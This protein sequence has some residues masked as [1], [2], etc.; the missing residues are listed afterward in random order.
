[1]THYELRGRPGSRA[2][3]ED[4]SLRRRRDLYHIAGAYGL[5]GGLRCADIQRRGD[6]VQYLPR[7]LADTGVKI[8]HSDV[9]PKSAAPDAWA[10]QRSVLF[11]LVCQSRLCDEFS[12]TFELACQELVHALRRIWRNRD[13]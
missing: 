9:A 4:P 3:L 12:P 6:G 7:L 2:N 13:V 1:M 10:P 5:H 11:R 8:C